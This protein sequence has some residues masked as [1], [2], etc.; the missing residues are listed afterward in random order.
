MGVKGPPFQDPGL[1]NSSCLWRLITKGWRGHPRWAELSP[2]MKR[3]GR[4]N[5]SGV[6]GLAVGL[7]T[8]FCGRA[9]PGDVHGQA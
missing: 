8:C 3:Q 2:C 1:V 9:H 6:P 7:G 4:G 5:G